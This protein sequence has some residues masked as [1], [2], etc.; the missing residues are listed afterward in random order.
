MEKFMLLIM[1]VLLFSCSTQKIAI[2]NNNN[3]NSELKSLL[4]T[5]FTDDKIRN[6]VYDDI[7]NTFYIDSILV[8][9]D[10]Q[11]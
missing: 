6:E 5:R 2:N 11:K 4:E 7:I 3:N 1:C 9:D 8:L 10:F